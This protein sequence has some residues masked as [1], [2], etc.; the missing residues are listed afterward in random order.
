MN[1]FA[2]QHLAESLEWIWG[3][4]IGDN[5]NRLVLQAL[6]KAEID[7]TMVTSDLWESLTDRVGRSRIQIRRKTAK[8]VCTI[9]EGSKSFNKYWLSTYYGQSTLL[10]T[11][12]TAVN[13]V[14]HLSAL[15]EL[16]VQN[17]RQTVNI[18]F[19]IWQLEEKGKRTERVLYPV[20]SWWL[21]HTWYIVGTPCLKGGRRR[22]ERKRGEGEERERERRRDVNYESEYLVC[23]WW[24]GLN[25]QS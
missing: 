17:S 23:Y 16:K 3:P 12:D 8:G 19:Q 13:K 24:Y 15:V 1:I 10:D 25:P 11:K 6:E 5:C 21:E 9:L 14:E 4:C 22:I 20:Y 2:L 7:S 18:Q